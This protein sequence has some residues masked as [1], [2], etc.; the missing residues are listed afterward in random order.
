MKR[1]EGFK[2]GDFGGKA[3]LRDAFSAYPELTLKKTDGGVTSPLQT[4]KFEEGQSI[5]E[6]ER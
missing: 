1:P 5:R 2:K 6:D 3:N 4:G